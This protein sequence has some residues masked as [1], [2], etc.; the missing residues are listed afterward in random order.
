MSDEAEEEVVQWLQENPCLYDKTLKDYRN[1]AKKNKL[2]ADKE[3]ELDI[4]KDR[5]ATWVD[6]KKTQYGKLTAKKPSGGP[7][8][9]LTQRDE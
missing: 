7:S 3:L 9:R 8:V 1:V 2:W 5:L 4:E 6:S